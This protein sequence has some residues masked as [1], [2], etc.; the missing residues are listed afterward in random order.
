[1][2]QRVV[3]LKPQIA[4]LNND[5]AVSEQAVDP[6]QKRSPPDL[7][8]RRGKRIALTALGVVLLLAALRYGYDWWAVGRF[9]E[10]TDDAYV[11]GDVTAISPR[12]S[13]FVANVLVADNQHVRASQTLIQLEPSTYQAAMD[14]AA[15]VVQQ[16]EAALSTLGAQYLLQQT[17][18]RQA[19]SDIAAKTASAAFAQEE[20]TRYSSLARTAA[21]SDQAAQRALAANKVAQAALDASRTRLEAANQQ[22]EVLDS[23][24]TA[25]KA[26]VKQAQATLRAA[27][28]DLGYTTVSAPIEGYVG[29]R[30]AQ[31]GAY[32]L[33]G[34]YLLSIVPAH[35]L[36]I[37]ANFKEDK[38]S[39][40]KPGLPARVVADVLPG[41]TFHGHVLSLAPATGS[42]FSVIPAQNAT[43]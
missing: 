8:V 19:R 22:L 38:I 27:R 4:N 37:D 5:D 35:G 39:R 21:G 29:G 1:M 28:L 34:A 32:V 13:G 23:E 17:M 15:A 43:I 6:G 16:R 26:A 2:I 41:M 36:W 10:T 42:V 11:G 33:A 3:K 25:A 24:T 40:M 30:S 12:V 7:P 18:I 20:E 14:G 31:R 9:I